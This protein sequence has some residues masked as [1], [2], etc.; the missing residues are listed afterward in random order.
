MVK[1]YYTKFQLRDML[2]DVWWNCLKEEIKKQPLPDQFSDILQLL[3]PEERTG[4][5]VE[6]FEELF[7][8][9]VASETIELS[10]KQV[11]ESIDNTMVLNELVN[12][13]MRFY[14]VNGI[15]P[16]DYTEPNPSD[17]YSGRISFDESEISRILVGFKLYIQ[18]KLIP[19]L[20]RL[21]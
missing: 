10:R 16:T 9:S 14:G 4:D 13:Y 19:V 17:P 6:F 8:E 2:L 21:W 20:D 3:P 12:N 11:A 7:R 15:F 18:T 5:F 1:M